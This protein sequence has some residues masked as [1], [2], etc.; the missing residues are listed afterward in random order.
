M[1]SENLL[2]TPATREVALSPNNVMI[3]KYAPDG[4]LEYV[5]DYFAE[6][7]GQAIYEIV[8]NNIA[9]SQS[10]DVPKTV[11]SLLNQSVSE[12]NN[13]NLILKNQASFG[14]FYWYYTDFSFS[15]DSEGTIQTITEH[16]RAVPNGN[17]LYE[18]EKLYQKLVKIEMSSGLNVAQKF[19]IGFNEE[20]GLSFQDYVKT[21]LRK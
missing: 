14:R 2:F 15:K 8:G 1:Q 10:P 4:T 3:C 18:I 9:A 16:R 17:G 21:L 5:N 13:I 11:L 7:H 12:G 20:N 6:I 19:F